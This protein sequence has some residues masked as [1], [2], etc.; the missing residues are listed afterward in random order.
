MD[1]NTLPEY[2]RDRQS[3]A[4]DYYPGRTGRVGDF[5][6][7]NPIPRHKV[8]DASN[9]I[10]ADATRIVSD[11]LECGWVEQEED[12]ERTLCEDTRDY[13]VSYWWRHSQFH[14][15]ATVASIQSPVMGDNVAAGLSSVVPRE[16][17]Y[18]AAVRRF[19]KDAGVVRTDEEPVTMS[20]I[21]DYLHGRL[22]R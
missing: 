3:R 4:I 15:W 10:R 13:Y 5:V 18:T 14:A 11:D 22:M 20:E 16:T 21:H 6:Y 7:C 9:R 1:F 19:L 17:D 12:V 8:Y 2:L